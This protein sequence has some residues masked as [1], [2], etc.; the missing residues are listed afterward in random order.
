MKEE[1]NK[2]T[3]D[4]TLT[5]EELTST[6]TREEAGETMLYVARV[7]DVRLTGDDLYASVS[8]KVVLECHKKRRNDTALQRAFN[9]F[10]GDYE[11]QW[12]SPTSDGGCNYTFLSVADPVAS[13]DPTRFMKINSPA[14]VPYKGTQMNAYFFWGKRLDAGQLCS[15]FGPLL[16]QVTEQVAE[17][18]IDFYQKRGLRVYERKE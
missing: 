4:E 5:T 16:R 13:H 14:R 10:F 15:T 9:Y 6:F 2:M 8:G 3:L 11:P 1:V 12:T 18:G 17:L 7:N